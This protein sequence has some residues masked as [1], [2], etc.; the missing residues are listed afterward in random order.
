M[1]SPVYMGSTSGSNRDRDGSD[2]TTIRGI[3]AIRKRWLNALEIY[4]IADLANA[5][6]DEI[7]AGAKR[8]GRSISRSELEEWI[9]QAQKQRADASVPRA[10]SLMGSAAALENPAISPEEP[11]EEQAGSWNVIASFQVEYQTQQVEGKLEQRTVIRQIGTDALE[12][13]PNFE[14]QLIQHWMGDRVEDALAQ[15]Q[16]G[17]SVLPEI[18]QLRVMQ[19]GQNGRSMTADKIHP[20]FASAIQMGEPFALEVAMQFAELAETTLKQTAYKVH[21]T[22]REL[23]TG[24]TDTLGEITA[25]VSLADNTYKVLLPELMLPRPGIYRLKVFVTL[26]NALEKSSSCF[27]VPMLQVV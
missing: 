13:W 1:E 16:P 17:L 19:F 4:T 24:L 14:T 8:D 9:A 25:I 20:L 10:E 21:C 18:T 5:S 22:A 3:G 12:D 26:Q 15:S 2:L 11:S 7:E 23:S 27:K 6:I